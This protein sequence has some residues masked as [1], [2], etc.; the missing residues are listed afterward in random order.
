MS[1]V[2]VPVSAEPLLRYCRPSGTRLENACFA[3]Y[4]DLIVFAAGFGYAHSHGAAAP[5]CRAFIEERQPHAIDYGVFRN[6]AYPLLLLLCIATTKDTNAVR[7]DEHVIRVLEN[8][9]A[10]GLQ[11]L[12]QK[13]SESNPDEFH[14]ELAQ[15][16]HDSAAQQAS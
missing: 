6:S 8:Y 2:R 12:S 7:D 9:A 15:L 1:T 14:V 13:L 5:A 10:V 4:A 16:L 3:T 11:A